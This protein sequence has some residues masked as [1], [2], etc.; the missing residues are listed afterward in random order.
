MTSHVANRRFQFCLGTIY[1]LA[2]IAFLVAVVWRDR[3]RLRGHQLQEAMYKVE[4][5]QLQNMAVSYEQQSQVLEDRIETST[6]E[7]KSVPCEDSIGPSE[8]H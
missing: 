8:H 6:G 5:A 3:L 1:L 2:I 4:I 7:L